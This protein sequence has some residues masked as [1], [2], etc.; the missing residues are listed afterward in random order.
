MSTHMVVDSNTEIARFKPSEGTTNPS[1]LYLAA[2]QPAY[3]ALL[4]RTTSYMNSLTALPDKR[5]ELG[6]EYLAV[7][8]GTEIYKLT[9]RVS[10][11]VDV[12]HSFHTQEPSRRP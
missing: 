9:G 3:A 2:Q 4:D 12:V 8:F 7:L 1:L 10:T 6:A 11:E 5:L